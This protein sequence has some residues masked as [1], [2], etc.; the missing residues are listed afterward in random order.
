LRFIRAFDT[1][2]TLGAFLTSVDCN[3]LRNVSVGTAETQVT[4]RARL[5]TSQFHACIVLLGRLSLFVARLEDRVSSDRASSAQI[6]SSK[7]RWSCVNI[8][9]VFTKFLSFGTSRTSVL[10]LARNRL[11]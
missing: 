1:E 6:Y 11:R 9:T 7:S 3:V 5:A 4:S 2:C 10:F 8:F